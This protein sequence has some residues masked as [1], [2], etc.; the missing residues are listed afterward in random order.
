RGRA[1][2]ERGERAR[3]R[4][5]F[6]AVVTERRAQHRGAGLK[7]RLVRAGSDLEARHSAVAYESP[8]E[9]TDRATTNVAGS[10]TGNMLAG[11]H[12]QV[13]WFADPGVGLRA[14]VGIHS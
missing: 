3:A 1:R 9:T 4:D 10:V 8:M 12:E 7:R 5:V 14:V 2:S 13:S 6:L 11:G